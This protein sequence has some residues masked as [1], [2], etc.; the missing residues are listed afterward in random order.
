M[1]YP[2]IPDEALAALEPPNPI[3]VG[4][5]RTA[6]KP[7]ADPPDGPLGAVLDYGKLLLAANTVT[8]L[9]GA[10][11]WTTLI[12]AHLM[13]CVIA[14]QYVPQDARTIADWGSG[15]GLPG[16]VWACLFPEKRML[17]CE[18]RGK[19]AEFLEDA[20]FRLELFNVEVLSGQ[21]EE[22]L[23][24]EGLREEGLV[25]V[26]V[27]RAVEA[28]EKLFKRLRRNKV[29]FG[30]LLLMAGPRW[31]QDWDELPD[32]VR[33]SWALTAQHAYTLPG[34]RGKRYLVALKPA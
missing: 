31:Q 12:E 33:K 27:A 11:D 16:L 10:R 3:D 4:V 28:P 19:R 7:L 22:C 21:A 24:E 5:L 9:T 13:D 29:K 1:A 17:L 14:A 32:N 2:G 26:I 18:R 6:L 23:R 20:A 30:A 15:G 25:D 34:D 8:N